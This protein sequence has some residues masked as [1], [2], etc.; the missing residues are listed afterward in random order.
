[1]EISADLPAQRLKLTENSA[2]FSYVGVPI[3]HQISSFGL[4]T[5]STNF[6][7]RESSS[8][9]DYLP[10]L[11]FVSGTSQTHFSRREL[12]LVLSHL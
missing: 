11:S 7:A 8:R 1:M 9:I 3:Q 6:P 4:G 10:T 12:I 5:G 2:S